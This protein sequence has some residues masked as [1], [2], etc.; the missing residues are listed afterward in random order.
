MAEKK[1]IRSSESLNSH[2]IISLPA[3]FKVT[4]IQVFGFLQ[5]VQSLVST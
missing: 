1:E 3:L 2:T 5:K 4:F